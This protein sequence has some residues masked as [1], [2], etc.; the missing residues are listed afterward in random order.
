MQEKLYTIN[1]LAT[2]FKMSFCTL[3]YIICHK[4]AVPS[5]KIGKNCTVLTEKQ[6]FMLFNY[7]KTRKFIKKRFDSEEC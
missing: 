2:I 1:S 6:V 3:D 4:K 7:I 5:H